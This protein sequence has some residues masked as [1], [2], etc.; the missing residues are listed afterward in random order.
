MEIPDG[1]GAASALRI[2][3]DHGIVKRFTLA[4]TYLEIT[5]RSRG[6]KAGEFSF[7][8]P[9]TPR[10]VF[11]KII[12]GDVYYHQVTILEGLR[13]DEIF[14]HFV[15]S[16]FGQE[17]EFRAAF[18]DVSLIS[19]LDREAVDLE[20]YLFPDT[21][22][23]QKGISPA[24]ILK[25]MVARF[26]E[27]FDQDMIAAAREIGFTM[28]EAV[29]LASLI[30]RETS[31]AEENALVSSVFHN[32]LRKRM[33]LQCDPTVIYVLAMRNQW[34]GNIRRRDLSIDSRYNTYRY[35]GLP[36]GPIGN[37]GA[38]AL[39]ASND[40]AETDYFYFVSKNTGRHQFSKTLNEH[41]R[42]VWEYQKKPYR[43]KQ[44]ARSRKQA[45]NN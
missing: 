26:R 25:M 14:D 15:R 30:E 21:Y 43:I 37:P 23:L 19:D 40:P 32:R 7:N 33:R 5:G 31:Q 39:R 27:I 2:L 34:D 17:E 6:I 11:D 12:A 18:R 4:L 38:A 1:A 41:N 9:M 13:S 3:E 44:L 16:G 42:A 24:T 10:A 8:R 35:F 20:G 45:R 28:R 36:P 22:S 29:T